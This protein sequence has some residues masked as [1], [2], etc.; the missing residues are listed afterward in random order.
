[1]DETFS[2]CSLPQMPPR[3]LPAGTC[4]A[5]PGRPTPSSIMLW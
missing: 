4:W 5:R 3:E 1:M 2:S